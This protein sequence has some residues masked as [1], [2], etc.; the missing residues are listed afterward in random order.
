MLSPNSQKDIATYTR[1][2]T[3]IIVVEVWT[4]GNSSIFSF[5]FFAC[6]DIHAPVRSKI[7]RPKR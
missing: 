5:F 3:R 6:F 2:L 4:E 1:S 7:V